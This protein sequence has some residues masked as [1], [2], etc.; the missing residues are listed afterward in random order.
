MGFRKAVAYFFFLFCGR[1]WRSIC[2]SS[3][4][5]YINSACDTSKGSLFGHRCCLTSPHRKI[6]HDTI[7]HYNSIVHLVSKKTPLYIADHQA[8]GIKYM[9]TAGRTLSI[10]NESPI[11]RR[12]SSAPMLQCQNKSISDVSKNSEFRKTCVNNL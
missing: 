8:G 3:I 1:L 7:V 2:S 4:S 6:S 5:L 11:T 12:I 9:R 10:Q